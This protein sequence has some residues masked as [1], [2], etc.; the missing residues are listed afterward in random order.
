MK[1]LSLFDGMS[2]GQIAFRENNIK[3]DKYYSFEIDKNAIKVTQSNFPNTVQCGDVFNADFT[4]FTDIDF[5]IGGSPCTY[6]SSA[7][8]SHREMQP[9]GVGWN[10]FKQYILALKIVKPKFFIYENNASISKSIKIQITNLLGVKPILI[11]SALVS[12]Q[13]R[14]RLY[15]VGM[16][17][18]VKYEQIPLNLPT[19]RFIYL[20]EILEKSHKWKPCGEWVR[21]RF[22]GR[23][24][25]ENLKTIE[26]LKAACCTTRKTHPQ[27]YICNKEK[28]QYFTLSLNEYKRL[29]T[30]PDWYDFS[31]ISEAQ[32]FKCI[33][34]G[35]TIEVIKYLISQIMLQK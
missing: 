29:Q 12:A 30:I 4:K 17:N 35:W 1:I 14:R 22:G 3:I 16:L 31:S 27:N 18:E 26:S 8:T 13:N 20:P 9:Q 25:L 6:W 32:A 24:K 28:T 23:S 10:L 33:G 21:G 7:N 2:C 15:W 19:D 5:L 34:N 11:N